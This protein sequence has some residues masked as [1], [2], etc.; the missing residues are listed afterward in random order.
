MT[1]KKKRDYH[2]LSERRLK[3]IK[4]Y[5]HAKATRTMRHSGLTFRDSY[6][7]ARI[8]FQIRCTTAVKKAWKAAPWNPY[9]VWISE[10]SLVKWLRKR[11]YRVYRKKDILNAIKNLE[12]SALVDWQFRPDKRVKR[13]NSKLSVYVRLISSPQKPDRP[14]LSFINTYQHP[15][16]KWNK[17]GAPNTKTLMQVSTDPETGLK[18]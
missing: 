1:K 18:Y 12:S 5:D 16:R 4:K 7:W 14:T 15:P 6:A 9:E 17:R 3:R 13:E 2:G 8:D 10:E 11:I